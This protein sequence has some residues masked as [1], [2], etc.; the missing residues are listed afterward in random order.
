MNAGF[1]GR[2]NFVRAVAVAQSSTGT[3]DITSIAI[4]VLRAQPCLSGV[5]ERWIPRATPSPSSPC[6]RGHDRAGS[7]EE[8]GT[9]RKRPFHFA[10][11]GELELPLL[12]RLLLAIVGV[13]FRN[14]DVARF[15]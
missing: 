15:S 13:Q 7:G 5:A 3:R 6:R 9:S 12:L 14:L 4:G 2:G 1:A 10:E 11:R 8:S